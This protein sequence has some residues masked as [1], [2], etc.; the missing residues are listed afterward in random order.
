MGSAATI[1][2]I[3]S[4]APSNTEII[5][6]LGLADR[7][8]AADKYSMEI[9]ELNRSITGIDFFY[10]DPE[11]IIGLDPDIIITSEHNVYGAGDDPFRLLKEMGIAVV[12]LPTS[13]SIA[14]IYRDIETIAAALGVLE[15][16]QELIRDMKEQIDSI[17]AKSNSITVKKS[18]YLEISPAPN[19]VS[20]GRE[21]FLD[22]MIELVGARNIFADKT[23][24]IAPGA[25]AVLERNPDV[26]LTNVNFIDEPI[27]EI[28]GRDGFNTIKAV[29]DNAV[30]VIDTDSSSRPTQHIILALR[31]IA[32]AVYPDY[33]E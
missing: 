6:G 4:T 7:I 26:I 16:G 10:P 25:E 18:V 21:T 31:Q 20:M 30:Y 14:G 19:M 12:Y 32:H 29:R 24:W 17:T 27:G 3:I 5:I 9:K 13:S 2:R 11:A 22:E 1:N 23:G 15:K 28:K 33:Y 8:I